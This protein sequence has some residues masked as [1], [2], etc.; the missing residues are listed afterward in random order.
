MSN[1]HFNTVLTHEQLS[2]QIFELQVL[3]EAATQNAGDQD[4]R[5]N[6]EYFLSQIDI[7]LCAL[8]EVYNDVS[9]SFENVTHNAL[10]GGQSW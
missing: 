9:I 6:L 1:V 8:A 2:D 7:K 3:L 10:V 4:K 5:P